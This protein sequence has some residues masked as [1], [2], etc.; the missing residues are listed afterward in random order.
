MFQLKNFLNKQSFTLNRNILKKTS[1]N[2]HKFNHQSL[3]TFSEK[4]KTSSQ[5]TIKSGFQKFIS[6]IRKQILKRIVIFRVLFYG[7]IVLVV[8]TVLRYSN[9]MNF[10]KNVT[11]VF[12]LKNIS[13]INTFYNVA[14][15]IKPGSINFLKGTDEMNFVLTDYE[16]ELKI[17]HKGVIPQ[18]FLEGNT[19]VATGSITDVDRPFIFMSTKLMTDHSYNSDKW[20]NRKLEK[21]D[22]KGKDNGNGII[23]DMVKKNKSSFVNMK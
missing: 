4:S 23:D 11:P 20:L 14:G 6:A 7:S 9:N 10:A 13:D 16:H 12:F 2:F 15:V 18:N 5:L 21:N 1:I 17:Y 8:F 19:C 22:A 3:K